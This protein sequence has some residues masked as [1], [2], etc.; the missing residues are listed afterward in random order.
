[1]ASC[2]PSPRVFSRGRR[3]F[4]RLAFAPASVLL[5]SKCLL[6]VVLVAGVPAQAQVDALPLDLNF[7]TATFFYDADRALLE[8][9]L[10]IGAA[11]LSYEATE[12]GFEDQVAIQLALRPAATAA[13][14]EASTTPVF[15][16][17]LN[18]T[19]QVADTTGLAQGQY[20]L[21]QVRAA[22]APGEYVL[23]VEV[24]SS[25]MESQGDLTLRRDLVVPD[26]QTEGR[27]RLADVTLAS[28]IARAADNAD[29]TFIKN[30]LDIRPSPSRL[31]GVGAERLF[32]YTEAYGLDG[33]ITDGEYTLLIRVTEANVTQPVEGLERRT[34][35]AVRSPD[36]LVGVFDVSELPSGSYFL[37]FVVLD[38]DNE[39]QAEQ[40]QKFFVF[41][42]DVVRQDTFEDLLGDDYM[43]TLYA[44]MPQEE[45]DANVEHAKVIA[46]AR[47]RRR[48]NDL[49]TEAAKREYL[50]EFW[51]IRDP[52][53]ATAINEA[54]RDFYDRLLQ[55]EERY[56]TNFGEAYESDQGRVMLKYGIPSVID[57]R[58][59]SGDTLPHEV[60]E[61]ENLPGEGRSL[62]VFADL[63]GFGTF[64]LIHSDVTGEESQL[65]WQQLLRR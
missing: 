39:A 8:V 47:E 54:R 45:L 29:P 38:A 65:N 22:I 6:L 35:R 17:T 7:D 10:A 25:S 27:A 52:N 43:T 23:E 1:M 30:G 53:S 59:A 36:V 5:R 18:L 60:W 14:D 58:R 34:T 46:T 42:P 11:S 3:P 64:E 33:L 2:S 61:Y 63:D 44:S 21:Q 4:R 51:R 26:Y 31:F 13:P 16:D 19:F 20:F 37:R 50:A 9:Y 56:A 41:N 15:A 40:A 49:A 32:Y 62:F 57:P 55:V 12:R 48:L 28:S 24:P